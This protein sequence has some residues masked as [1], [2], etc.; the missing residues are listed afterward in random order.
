MGGVKAQQR[1]RISNFANY[2]AYTGQDQN[3]I[4]NND[5][6]LVVPI[7]GIRNP[8]EVLGSSKLNLVGGFGNVAQD[9]KSS[10]LYGS[11]N[12]I[13]EFDNGVAIGKDNLVGGIIPGEDSYAIGKR[14]NPIL[15][16]SMALGFGAEENRLNGIGERAITIGTYSANAGEAFNTLNVLPPSQVTLFEAPGV[17]IGTAEPQ[18]KLNIVNR[19]ATEGDN[20]ELGVALNVQKEVEFIT[21]GPE[22]GPIPI[23]DRRDDLF[24]VRDDGAAGFNIPANPGRPRAPY[25]FES[26]GLEPFGDGNGGEANIVQNY[27]NFPEFESFPPGVENNQA[28][29]L[30]LGERPP[31]QN[32]AQ[33]AYGLAEVWDNNAGNF[34]L[35]DQTPGDEQE[36]AAKDL[37]I[38]F[39]DVTTANGDFAG[40]DGRNRLRFLFRNGQPIEDP[41]GRFELMSLEPTGEVG[42]GDYSGNSTQQANLEVKAET[43]GNGDPVFQ[44]RNNGGP[45]DRGD[46]VMTANDDGNVG[47]GEADPD[48]KLVVDGVI[49]PAL[50]NQFD[51]GRGGNNNPLRFVD[52]NA[53]GSIVS[54]SDKRMKNNID[55]LNYGLEEIMELRPVN[56][57]MKGHSE[58]GEQLGLIAQ[59][60][61]D[62]I[63]EVVKTYDGEMGMKG[64][65]YSRIIPVLINGMQEQQKQVQKQVQK[66]QDEIEELQA[67]LEQEKAEN[68][69]LEEKVNQLSER[70]NQLAEQVNGVS[71]SFKKA[72]EESLNQKTATIS[73]EDAN[74]AMLLQNRPNPYSNE[75]VIPYYLPENAQNANML[76]TNTQGQMLKRIPLEGTGKGELT[77]QTADLKKGQYQYTLII[78][79][80]Q[81]Q[82]RKMIVK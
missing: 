21:P 71:Q 76:I 31:G 61:D 38:T 51:L 29:W 80:R 46:L 15:S 69:A 20:G 36:T 22:P 39:Q 56:Y 82:T 5:P 81:I 4:I 7:G 30:A 73:S 48:E 2:G 19:G 12:S 32:D 41:A 55:S 13:E 34:V 24:N 59:E 60:V 6:A 35:L 49:A 42:V 9:A 78:D 16:E 74:Q 52:I 72:D 58:R 64:I 11:N 62:V 17:G 1:D 43:Q 45:D 57:M 18:G 10:L 66:Q 54:T 44:V 28:K 25:Q 70:V 63:K 65:R 53:T 50:D 37:A 75:T 68:E 8:N 27:S 14:L 47:I 23:P 26:T 33:V 77:L 67:N 3:A 40:R 79:G